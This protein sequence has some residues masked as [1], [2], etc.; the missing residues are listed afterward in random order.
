MIKIDRLDAHDRY[1]H[2]TTQ[3]FSI[4]ECCQNL[5]DQKPF[6]NHPFYIWAHARTNDDGV[7]KRIIWQPRLTRPTPQT[8]SMLFKAYPGT[9]VIKICWIIPAREMWPTY[10]K[11]QM[12]QNEMIG[13]FI[14]AFDNNR[15]LLEKPED[16]DY[17]DEKIDQ[18][19]REIAQE[20]KRNK[21]MEKLYVKPTI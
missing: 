5:I 21:S 13:G 19:Y 6:G 11:G 15:K 14:H 18:I 17:S 8:N 16:D 9:D 1:K 3:N 7:S 10:M 2:F 20:A 4:E 12:C